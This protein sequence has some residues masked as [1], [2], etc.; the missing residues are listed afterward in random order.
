MKCLIV[1]ALVAA[2]SAKSVLEELKISE[3]WD[4]FKTQFEKMYGTEEEEV[5][6]YTIFKGEARKI[7]KI[8]AQ[9]LTFQLGVNQF[10][11]MTDEEYAQVLGYR[12]DKSLSS[13]ES[14]VGNPDVKLPSEV[15]WV[16][17]GYVTPIKNQGACGSCWAFS[18][19]GSTE[20]QHFKKTGNLVSLSEQNLVD[21]SQK[22]GDHGCHG[23][24]MDFGFKY[25]IENHGIDTEESYPYTAKDGT[26]RFKESHVGATIT[27]YKDVLPRKSESSLQEA[28][29]TIGPV[30]VAIDASSTYF[31]YYKHGVLIDHKCSSTRL[32]H[33]V[34]AVGYGVEEEQDYWLVKNSWGT[35]WGN[36]GYIMMARNHENMCGI[37]TAASYPIA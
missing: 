20:G 18:T 21:C 30:S 2:V 29:A 34:L 31:R 15:D 36:K 10:A 5:R 33:G 19:T 7:E 32:D 11:D 8:N 23:G 13:A 6:R 1:L 16:T 4:T 27:S 17:K 14:F 3:E 35:S 28:V 26:C 12:Q 37:S 9:N 24:L 25:I 22:E